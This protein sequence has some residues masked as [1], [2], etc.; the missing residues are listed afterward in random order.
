MS[1]VTAE[2][3]AAKPRRARAPKAVKAERSTEPV[4]L[5]WDLA[6]L[7]SSQHKAGLA[8]LALCVQFLARKRERRGTCEL[9]A[10]DASGLT[11]RVDRVGMQA[12]FD[13]VYAATLEEQERDKLFQK[14]TAA[15]GK[16]DVPPK[17]TRERQVTDKKGVAKTKTFY[18]YEQTVPAGELV[19]SW[20]VASADG[21]QL[22]LK[23]WRDVVWSIFRGVPA[24][25][26]PYDARAERRAIH[27]GAEEWDA[28]TGAPDASVELPST[29]YLG[30]QARSAENVAFR[31]VARLRFLLHFWPFVAP[32]YVPAVTGRDGER[33]FAGFALVIPDVADLEEF[34]RTWEQVAR[35]RG[36]EAAGYCPRD[37]VVDVAAEAGLDVARRAFLVVGRR[38]G[39][40]LTRPWLT[41]VD[42][43]HVEKDG[44]NVRTRSVGRVDLRR[45]R[46][47][48]YGRVRT[49]YWSP[50]FRRQRI[51]NILDPTLDP[52]TGWVTGF[53]RLCAT[54]PA[55]LT[56]HDKKFRHD[57]RVAFTEVEMTEASASDN[58]NAK[59]LDQL[60][61][62]VARSYVFGKLSSKYA[63]EWA[64]A[65]GTPAEKDYNEKKDKIAREA[66]L[67]VRSRTGADFVTYFTGTLCSVSQRVG[68][69]GYL[70][71]ARA[72]G[73]D[74]E[75][76]RVRSLT[77]LALSAA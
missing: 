66:F 36:P 31:D 48:A 56:I 54:S 45:D 73:D 46:A 14:K 26:E 74:R 28:L 17:E 4:T 1:D 15:G 61:Y 33:E 8:G 2:A 3:S 27:D 44:N 71:L 38:E 22:W 32:I 42:V 25:R 11:L 34:V 65:K 37:A 5:R 75:V 29:Y 70:E 18:V 60:I 57:C 41:A 23:L 77:L 40:A 49:A 63:L 67:A 21:K 10:I 30:A 69:E 39:A 6:E 24:T 7:P 53:G 72:L 58:D 68:Q 64:K 19:G 50:L 51:T 47:D 55:E 20:D 13:D 9:V 43:F 59:S 62:Q 52:R 76:E 16:V 35:E 12:L